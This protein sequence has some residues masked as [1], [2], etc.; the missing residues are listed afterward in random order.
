MGFIGT[1][2]YAPNLHAALFLAEQVFPQ[3]L[4]ELPDA[5]LRLAGANLPQASIA[6]LQ[7]LPQVEIL[8]QV[9]DSGRFMD[10]CAV[11]ALPVFLRGGVP[12]KLVEAMARGKAIVASPEVIGGLNIADGEAVVIRTK[13][14]DF[15]S[16][17]VTLLR[18]VSLRER[19][20]ANAR[21]TF[22]R[23]FSISSAEAMLRRDSVLVK[24]D[25][26]TLRR[27]DS[28]AR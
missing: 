8:G 13:A 17:I 9:A 23:D 12:L 21:V 24:H 3:V 20:G 16:A 10:E 26:R 19:M 4:R 28:L 6:K 1:Y 15:A 5:V 14:E 27:K 2:S 18:D 7:G 11:L 22:E 25:S